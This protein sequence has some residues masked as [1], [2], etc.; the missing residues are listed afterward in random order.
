MYVSHYLVINLRKNDWE[1]LFFYIASST[2]INYLTMATH[3]FPAMEKWCAG[4]DKF[5][6]IANGFSTP[7]PVG[8]TPLVSQFHEAN[9]RWAQKVKTIFTR[10]GVSFNEYTSNLELLGTGLRPDSI[11]SNLCQIIPGSW[12]I[13][14]GK[15]TSVTSGYIKVFFPTPRYQRRM[16]LFYSDGDLELACQGF[17]MQVHDWFCISNQ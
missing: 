1:C 4:K 6:A 8:N 9:V 10:N 13:K 3:I 5:R 12:V 11:I 15:S 14:H 2:P 16:V 17:T 7:F